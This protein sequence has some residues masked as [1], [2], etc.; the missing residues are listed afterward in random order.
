MTFSHIHRCFLIISLKFVH[1]HFKIENLYNLMKHA[2]TT[3]W[4]FAI[5]ASNKSSY[6]IPKL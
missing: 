5:F 4:F 1:K 6:E 3:D 2:Q